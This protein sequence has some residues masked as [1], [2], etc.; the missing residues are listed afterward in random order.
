MDIQSL[1]LASLVTIGVVNVVSFFKPNLY[2]RLKFTTAFITAFIV[3]FIPMEL[4]NVILEKAKVAIEI[5][6][7][8]SGVFKLATR[9]GGIK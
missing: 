3:T 2:S 9:A 7:A 6:F 4:G 1:T 8:S 5:A